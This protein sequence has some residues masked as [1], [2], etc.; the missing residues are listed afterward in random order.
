M[1]FMSHL[2]ES[3]VLVHTRNE[4]LKMWRQGVLR[5]GDLSPGVQEYIIDHGLEG[6][7]AGGLRGVP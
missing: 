3:A 7:R 6:P 2:Y 5:W 1:R 4:V